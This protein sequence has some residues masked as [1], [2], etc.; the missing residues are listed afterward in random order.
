MNIQNKGMAAMGDLMRMG[1]EARR[2]AKEQAP[3]QSEGGLVVSKDGLSFSD[4]SA[5]TPGGT[6]TGPL[7]QAIAHQLTAPI[8][9]WEL[10]ELKRL[11]EASTPGPWTAGI[12]YYD[13]GVGRNIKAEKDEIMGEH[14]PSDEDMEYIAAANPAVVLLLLDTI[15]SQ[16]QVSAGVEAD[17]ARWQTLQKCEHKAN[18]SAFGVPFIAFEFATKEE[19]AAWWKAIQ[20]KLSLNE[21]ID[22]ARAAAP[23]TPHQESAA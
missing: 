21:I 7:A 8:Q 18:A 2:A 5:I 16:R 23:V 12:G 1:L 6:V 17:A 11:A 14:L 20:E 15:A 3:T 9:S 10:A 4:G 13:N 19:K 22:A